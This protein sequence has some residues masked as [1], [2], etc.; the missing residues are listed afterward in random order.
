MR[1][2]ALVL[3]T[4]G[5]EFILQPLG[6]LIVFD[7]AD[8]ARQGAGAGIQD[9]IALL[10]RSGSPI[11]A[12]VRGMIGVPPDAGIHAQIAQRLQPLDWQPFPIGR[13]PIGMNQI[14]ANR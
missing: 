14:G 10:H 1:L 9:P 6:F 3:L 5:K 2:P 11:A 4:F 13:Q 7:S 12:I 8:D